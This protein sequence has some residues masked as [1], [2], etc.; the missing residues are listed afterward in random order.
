MKIIKRFI[1]SC[2][3][4]IS[5]TVT[6][7][8]S[9]ATLITYELQDFVG[10]FSQ[11]DLMTEWFNL[12]GADYSQAITSFEHIYS[13]NNRFSHLTID[14][15]MA[16]QG[17]WTIEAGLDAGFGA[18]VYIDGQSVFKDSSNL[19]WTYRWHHEDVVRL[20][21]L[22]FSP[23]R[24]KIEFFWL[25]NCCNGYNTLRLTD[26]ISG[27]T[28]VLSLSS[29]QAALGTMPVAEPISFAL[30]ILGLLVLG[31]NLRKQT[32]KAKR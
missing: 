27:V 5:F 11:A 32:C 23:G 3:L 13:G 19:W 29:L 17:L 8:S 14:F 10:N 20:E 15:I 6:S 25:E 4:S 31:L 1:I 2:T 7:L 26:R 12:G 30:F 21:N 24:H 18:Q 28:S 22:V 9:H 16:E